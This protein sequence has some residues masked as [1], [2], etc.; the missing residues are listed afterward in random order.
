MERLICQLRKTHN[1]RKTMEWV[2][3]NWEYILVAFYALEKIV[4]LTP[5]TKDDIIF[6]CV[7]KPVWDKLPFGKK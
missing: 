6:D 4:K 3:A 5:T 2:L 1:R 7:I